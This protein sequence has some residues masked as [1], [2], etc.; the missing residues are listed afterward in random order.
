M[1]CC[2]IRWFANSTVIS[3]RRRCLN[4]IISFW[5]VLLN[6]TFLSYLFIFFFFICFTIHPFWFVPVLGNSLWQAPSLCCRRVYMFT[7]LLWRWIGSKHSTEELVCGGKC[8]FSFLYSVAA[9][10]GPAASSLVNK[11]GF[12]WRLAGVDGP[13]LERKNTN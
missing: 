3:Y 11:G 9:A 1:R 5:F 6:V 2:W 7:M 8:H 4:T 10:A 13:F 12:P